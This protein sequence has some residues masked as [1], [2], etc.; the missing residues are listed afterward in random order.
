VAA[1]MAVALS[2][3]V[4]GEP[5]ASSATNKFAVRCPGAIGLNTTEIVQ[6]AETATGAAQLLV[7]LK[8]PGFGPPS[9]TP[10]RCSVALPVLVTVTVCAALD[11]PSVVVEND[12]PLDGENVIAGAA[13]T[14][15]PLSARLCGLPGALSATCKLAVNVPALAGLN[16][17]VTEQLALAA[18]VAAQVLVWEKLLALVPAIVTESKESDCVPVFTMEKTCVALLVPATAV[19]F[20]ALEGKIVAAG[21]LVACPKLPEIAKLWQHDEFPASTP[22]LNGDP[23]I[24]MRLPVCGSTW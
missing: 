3:T 14:P 12:G 23:I 1:R 15:V 13:A 2:A 16:I 20:P 17:M 18:S 5:P 10:E 19:K 9:E 4:C 11:V 6:L 22:G 7:K 8:S 24:S 21:P